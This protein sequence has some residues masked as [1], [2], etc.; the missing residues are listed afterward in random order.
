MV[1][2]VTLGEIWAIAY[3]LNWGGKKMEALENFLSRL[4]SLDISDPRIVEAYARISAHATMNGW[5]LHSQKNDLWIA[6][7]AHVTGATLLT[8]DK[9]FCQANGVFVDRVLFDNE[10]GRHIP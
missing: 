6:A 1:C 10:T 8:T 7:T 9:D 3:R 5:A 4:V 2:V